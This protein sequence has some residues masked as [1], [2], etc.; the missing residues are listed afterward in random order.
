MFACLFISGIIS[1]LIYLLQSFGFIMKSH[2]IIKEVPFSSCSNV[3]VKDV[4]AK[5]FPMLGT[6][7]AFRLIDLNHDDVLDVVLGFSTGKL[8]T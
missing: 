6:E 7:S 3:K 5:T 4:W 1:L 8:P 2:T